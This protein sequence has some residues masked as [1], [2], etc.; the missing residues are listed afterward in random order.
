MLDAWVYIQYEYDQLFMRNR[1]AARPRLPIMRIISWYDI[2]GYYYILHMPE[3]D[4]P[5]EKTQCS[6]KTILF[7]VILWTLYLLT[8]LLFTAYCI[9]LYMDTDV[10]AIENDTKEIFTTQENYD[11]LLKL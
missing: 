3:K 6:S 5:E 7:F 4:L 8:C 10:S 2:L 1:R 9:Q 11:Y